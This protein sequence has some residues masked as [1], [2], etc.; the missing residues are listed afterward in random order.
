MKQSIAFSSPSCSRQCSL[1]GGATSTCQVGHI[2]VMGLARA[3]CWI[4]TLWQPLLVGQGL[5]IKPSA[6]LLTSRC[7]SHLQV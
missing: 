7:L 1:R 5:M 4:S 2:G 6:G 3:L